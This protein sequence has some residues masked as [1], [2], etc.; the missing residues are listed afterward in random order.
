ML[1]RGCVPMRICV[2]VRSRVRV[3]DCVFL[4]ARGKRVAPGRGRRDRPILAETRARWLLHPRAR[5][6]GNGV[7]GLEVHPQE[8]GLAHRCAQQHQKVRQE[9]REV[10][11]ARGARRPGGVRGHLT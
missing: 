5:P 2:R 8:A 9:Q 4:L 10:G 1:V 11:S 3:L 6:G 7:S